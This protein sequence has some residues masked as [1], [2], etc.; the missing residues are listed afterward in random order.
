MLSKE[1]IDFL[2]EDFVKRELLLWVDIIPQMY[3]EI[4]HD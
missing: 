3:K 4:F 2:E 1:D